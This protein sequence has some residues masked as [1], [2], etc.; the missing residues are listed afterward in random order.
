MINNKFYVYEWYNTDTNEVFYVGKGCGKRKDETKKRNKK[1]LSYI[2]THSIACRIIKDN[3]SEEEALHLEKEIIDFYKEKNECDYNLMKGG[4]GG[5]LLLFGQ[6][7]QNALE[8]I[9]LI[10]DIFV[11]MPISSRASESQ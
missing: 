5:E 1:F 4:T 10:K 8:N 9:K 3:L 6:R 7:K 11:N 2:E